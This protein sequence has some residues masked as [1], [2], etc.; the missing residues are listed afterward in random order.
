MKL[1]YSYIFKISDIEAEC[2]YKKYK[3]SI[4]SL[5][6]LVDNVLEYTL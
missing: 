5:V 1:L 3:D 2:I 4:R 6:D